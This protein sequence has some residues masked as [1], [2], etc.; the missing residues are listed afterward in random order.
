MHPHPPGLDLVDNGPFWIR[1]MDHE[2]GEPNGAANVF[3]GHTTFT[4][5]PLPYRKA[6][7]HRYEVTIDACPWLNPFLARVGPGSMFTEY[8][9]GQ[10]TIEVGERYYVELLDRKG[11]KDTVPTASELEAAILKGLA[12]HG[13][14]AITFG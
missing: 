1:V 14:T 13:I 10:D 9:D 11:T 5:T 3:E 8:R 12:P 4:A 6:W 7:G 2:G